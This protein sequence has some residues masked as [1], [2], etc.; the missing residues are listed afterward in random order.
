[1]DLLDLCAPTPK[2]PPPAPHQIE[3]ARV[4]T[5]PPPLTPEQVRRLARLQNRR[6]CYEVEIVHPDGRR[7]L[8]CYSE[9][10]S[11]SAV[12]QAIEKRGR[13]VIAFLG[14]DD[15]AAMTWQRGRREVRIGGAIVRFTGRTQRDAIM[16][17]KELPYVGTLCPAGD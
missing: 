17:G 11:M 13:S 14:M 12:R 3:T 16:S 5:P 10:S 15:A 9:A 7:A 4:F 8:L 6:T 1:M 2:P